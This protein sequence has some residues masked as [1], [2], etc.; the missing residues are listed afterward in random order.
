MPAARDNSVAVDAP[1]SSIGALAHVNCRCASGLLQTVR[2]CHS[3][4]LFVPRAKEPRDFRAIHNVKYVHSLDN[5][6]QCSGQVPGSS[7]SH[8]QQSSAWPTS[9]NSP[10]SAS[11]TSLDSVLGYH[12][13]FRNFLGHHLHP[14]HNP[15]HQQDRIRKW[16]RE[17]HQGPK[18]QALAPVSKGPQQKVA[19]WQHKGECCLAR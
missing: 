7:P 15:H 16:K 12:E 17:R 14:P 8:G 6:H 18:P 9:A 10:R 13:D 3:D 4:R 11:C 5:Q 19:S 2:K 1:A